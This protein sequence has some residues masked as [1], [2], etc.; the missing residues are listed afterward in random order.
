MGRRGGGPLG[1]LRPAPRDGGGLAGQVWAGGGEGSLCWSVA[2]WDWYPAAG[3]G[4]P[5]LLL[6]GGGGRRGQVPASF[7]LFSSTP[8][9]LPPLLPPSSRPSRGRLGS[10]S[11][12]APFSPSTWVGG[13]QRTLHLSLPLVGTPPRE[14]ALVSLPFSSRA[15]LTPKTPS[16]GRFAPPPDEGVLL[17][18]C[19]GGGGEVGSASP[20]WRVEG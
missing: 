12:G 13:G 10:S 4:P 6:L 7:A 1:P 9:S 2:P 16:V 8:P 19:F 15:G 18:S 14:S 11:R 5:P 20:L 3:A 17:H